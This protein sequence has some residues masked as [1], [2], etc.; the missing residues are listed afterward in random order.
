MN[1]Y[2]L[3]LLLVVLPGCSLNLT[4]GKPT[5]TPATTQVK[6]T[7]PTTGQLPYLRSQVTGTLLSNKMCPMFIMPNWPKLAAIPDIDL[8]HTNLDKQA[9]DKL[10]LLDYIS[11]LRTQFID[12]R[13]DVLNAYTEYLRIC[14]Y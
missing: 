12:I 11:K 14:E 5:T 2:V 8:N 3:A 9:E 10:A 7:S 13:T 6:T 4:V 1:K